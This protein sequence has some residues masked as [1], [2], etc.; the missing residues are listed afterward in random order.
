MTENFWSVI[1]PPIQFVIGR[2]QTVITVMDAALATLV[3]FFHCI[4]WLVAIEY[5]IVAGYPGK[6]AC[7]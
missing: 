3:A 2:R 6:V 7:T 5:R 1:F 4:A